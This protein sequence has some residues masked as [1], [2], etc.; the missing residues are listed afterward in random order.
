MLIIKKSEVQKSLEL[1]SKLN[2][3]SYGSYLHQFIQVTLN[4]APNEIVGFKNIDQK[5]INNPELINK[6]LQQASFIHEYKHFVDCFSTT[7]GITLFGG[8]I[9]EIKYFLKA[10][11]YL[12]AK[13]IKWQ[14]PVKDWV[15][16]N[17]CPLIIK[18][19]VKSHNEK[20]LFRPIYN[21]GTE[22]LNEEG[23]SDKVWRNAK[24]PQLGNFYFPLYPLKIENRKYIKGKLD[25]TL[26]RT[27]WQ[28][29]GFETLIEGNAQAFQRSIIG[30]QFSGEIEN[31]IWKKFTQNITKGANFN[32]DI[33]QLPS[34]YNLTDF[35]ITKFL[36]TRHNETKFD[37]RLLTKIT[38]I[39]LMETIFPL[40]PNRDWNGHPGAR[41]VEILQTVRKENG[42][43]K[44]RNCLVDNASIKTQIENLKKTRKK[45]EIYIEEFKRLNKQDPV[46][47]IESFVQ[48]EIVIPLL[49][50]R[51]DRGN[52]IFSDVLLFIKHFK[53]FP[54]P[55]LTVYKNSIKFSSKANQPI[56]NAWI[57][58]VFISSIFE[59]IMNNSKIICC[60]R[61]YR[62]TSGIERFSCIADR[63]YNC[64]QFIQ[65]RKCGT[66]TPFDN[67]S[68]SVNCLFYLL[69]KDLQL[70]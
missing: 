46:T 58:F 54:E 41:F 23:I 9:N 42:K 45:P 26:F 30:N 57:E 28:S 16:K 15:K 39:A 62:I 56:Q 5:N 6:I 25:S 29:I 44:T 18:N 2:N 24:T 36:N 3:E 67:E 60:P 13:K 69:M 12:K 49:Q 19:L 10:C 64:E 51:L 27:S 68:K 1:K 40:N 14:L 65:D 21:G 38:D 48:H 47:I 4:M 20:R 22:F 63:K 59:Q 37:R 31:Q 32:K 61:F 8:I 7:A 35:L 34:H 50:L 33:A 53:D 66:Y 70:N 11:S 52:E 17:T 55:L 43:F